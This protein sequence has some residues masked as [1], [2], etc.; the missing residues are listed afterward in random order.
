MYSGSASLVSH[1]VQFG[2]GG[3]VYSTLQELQVGFG[4]GVYS[5]TAQVL[6][7]GWVYS[8]FGYSLTSQ[9]LQFGVSYEYE[10]CGA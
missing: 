4:G 3:G 2:V 10:G 5:F 7:L 6:Q 8:T 9:V 1:V